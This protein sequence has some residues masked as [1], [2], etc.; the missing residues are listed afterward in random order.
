VDFGDEPPALDEIR[1]FAL[2]KAIEFM[3]DW[4]NA[5]TDAVIEAAAKFERYLRGEQ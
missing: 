2:S 3:R 5:Q 4:P 1:A